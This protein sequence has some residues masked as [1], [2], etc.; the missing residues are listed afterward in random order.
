[1]GQNSCTEV[2]NFSV[3]RVDSSDILAWE[4]G[5]AEL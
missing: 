1:M 2:K 5:K 4:H 3:L